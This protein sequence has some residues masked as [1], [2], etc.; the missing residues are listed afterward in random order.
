MVRNADFDAIRGLPSRWR[1]LF[2]AKHVAIVT[3]AAHDETRVQSK[4]VTLHVR[5]ID[6]LIV[7]VVIAYDGTSDFRE[8]I[9]I[10]FTMANEINQT[11]KILDA[12]RSAFGE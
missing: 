8:F 6:R 5:F 2:V 3:S 7:F 4:L 9:S 11:W 1:T 10:L 12:H